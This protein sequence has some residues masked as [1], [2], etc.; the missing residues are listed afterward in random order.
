MG[1]DWNWKERR[2]QAVTVVTIVTPP[3]AAKHDPATL[4]TV[5]TFRLLVLALA[6]RLSVPIITVMRRLVSWRL[7]RPLLVVKSCSL[8]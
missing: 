7:P 4:L 5:H 3:A 2:V 8:F 6:G 1:A